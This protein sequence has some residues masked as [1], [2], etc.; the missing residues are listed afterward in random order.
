M[1]LSPTFFKLSPTFLGKCRTFFGKRPMF[2]LDAWR[3]M[4]LISEEYFIVL[5][6]FVFC[7]SLA[8]ARA[9]APYIFALFAFTTFTKTGVVYWNTRQC[10]G[11]RNSVLQKSTK[12]RLVEAMKD[13][14]LEGERVCFVSHFYEN[15]TP[16]GEG[17]ESKKC[18]F[19]GNARAYTRKLT[20][21]F[22]FICSV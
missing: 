14:I 17:C 19:A 21:Y 10:K 22:L 5:H 4:N 8:R 20:L 16:I 3:R 2:L 9:R 18:M 15:S 1:N 13:V 12:V 11:I 6:I 7:T